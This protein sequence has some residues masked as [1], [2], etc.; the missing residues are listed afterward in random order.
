[1]GK[2]LV[3]KTNR[4][5]GVICDIYVSELN[6]LMVKLDN[7]DGT[8]TT[9]NIGKYDPCDNIFTKALNKL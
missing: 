3:I 7:L 1:M 5:E 6:Y 8:Y 4:L 2:D 9:Y